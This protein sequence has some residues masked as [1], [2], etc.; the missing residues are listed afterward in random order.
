MKK[1]VSLLLTAALGLA[2]CISAAAAQYTDVREDFWAYREIAEASEKGWF[3][4]Y[5]DGQFRPLGSIAR[6]EA[7]KV[8]TVFSG[9]RI[10]QASGTVYRDIPADMWCAP[11]VEA[12]RDL[13]PAEADALA[14][15]PNEPMTREVTFVALIRAMGLDGEAEKAS[16]TPLNAFSDIGTLTPALRPYAALA[17]QYGLVNG[18][19]DG[20]IR[21]Q[22]TLTRAEFAALLVRCEKKS[23]TSAKSADSCVLLNTFNASD[24]HGAVVPHYRLLLSDGTEKTAAAADRRAVREGN[25]YEYTRSGESYTLTPA[26]QADHTITAADAG[27]TYLS[28]ETNSIEDPAQGI[29]IG[30]KSVPFAA[31]C[32]F[33][34]TNGGEY[35]VSDVLWQFSSAIV[36]Y[37]AVINE[38]G[39]VSTLY[40]LGVSGKNIVRHSDDLVFI[41]AAQVGAASQIGAD[42]KKVALHVYDAFIDGEY[43]ENF[44][45]RE[46]VTTGFYVNWYD[47]SSGW[48]ILDE[49]Y[50]GTRSAIRTA[51][52][53]PITA[54][55]LETP[56]ME[57]DGKDIG[58]SSDTKY[59]SNV[60]DLPISS[61]AE[62]KTA[63]EEHTALETYILYNDDTSRILYIYVTA[64]L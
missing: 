46:A 9:R 22:D 19:P 51:E 32:R 13:F 16:L 47:V 43:Q 49:K 18:F 62:L 55:M 17:V 57:I 2:L 7:M 45:A 61:L 10:A 8:V 21:G 40:I 25:V 11:Y 44:V 38:R 39:Q 42:G 58:V 63:A 59:A 30:T 34:Y 12:G 37:A 3:N 64:V 20:T 1:L 54:A 52:A 28:S 4:G 53:Q 31:D 33:I 36:R 48:Y 50:D 15:R 6:S 23:E 56:Y 26:A 24:G 14:F 27:R 29:M 60:E 35:T 41:D 5:P